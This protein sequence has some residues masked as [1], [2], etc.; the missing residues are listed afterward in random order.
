MSDLSAY[1]VAADVQA[2]LES[3]GV[4]DADAGLSLASLATRASEKWES[5]T[6][7]KP[8]LSSGDEETK[9]YNAPGPVRRPPSTLLGGGDLLFLQRGVLSV[10]ELTVDGTEKT[11]ETDYWLEPYDAPDDGWPYL[12]VRFYAPM[13][14]TQRGVAITGVWGFCLTLSQSVF[15]AIV[16][17]ACLLAL[18]DLANRRRMSAEAAQS[19]LV[20]A[21]ETGPVRTEY[22]TADASKADT[23][24]T[25]A[26]RLEAEYSDAV[27]KHRMVD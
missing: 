12:R 9:Y 25:L 23:L 11:A 10:S 26:A 5:D 1:P 13:W 3:T 2:R 24:A 19:T 15:D 17:Q 14:S 7:F 4:Y 18:P 22:A 6:E 16:A 27:S 21:K 8:F 20:K